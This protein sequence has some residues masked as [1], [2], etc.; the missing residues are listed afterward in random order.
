MKRRSLLPVLLCVGA[1]VFVFA[2]WYGYARFL[3][4]DITTF[5]SANLPEPLLHT[6]EVNG[7]AETLYS[8]DEAVVLF[9]VETRSARAEDAQKDNARAVKAIRKVLKDDFGLSEQDVQTASYRIHHTEPRPY[10]IDILPENRLEIPR[11]PSSTQYEVRHVLRVK[12]RDFDR[13][14]EII[15]A[16]VRHGANSVAGIQFHGTDT[17]QLYQQTVADA[18]RNARARAEAVA[19]AAGVE[20]KG[21]KTV[22]VLN[23]TAY[24]RVPEA[25]LT[26]AMDASGTVIDPEELKVTASVRVVFIID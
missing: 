17:E 2:L 9:G 15:D 12:V 24:P 7:Y 18:V 16:A 26:R 14:G 22:E 21:I 23:H 13:L 8:P 10:T 19:E 6:L 11:L 25:V 1:L 5:P 3:T 20:I 4:E